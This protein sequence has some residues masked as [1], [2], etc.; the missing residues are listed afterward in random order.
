VTIP[1]I[2]PQTLR[3]LERFIEHTTAWRYGYELS[4]ETGLKSGTLAALAAR[5]SRP[6]QAAFYAFLA[7]QELKAEAQESPSRYRR[8]SGNQVARWDAD[9]AR[10]SGAVMLLAGALL[11]ATLFAVFLRSRSLRVSSLR[12]GRLAIAVGVSSSAAFFCLKRCS[13]SQLSALCS[14]L[15][16]FHP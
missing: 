11:L 12:P 13:A 8:F 6:A 9:L 14:N 10:R 1:R 5:S 7:G 4:R 3:V 2:S 16:A 15:A